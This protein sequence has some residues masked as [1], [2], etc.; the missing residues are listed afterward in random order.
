M[1]WT[2]TP[3]TLYEHPEHIFPTLKGDQIARFVAYG[4]LREVKS[5]QVLIEQGDQSFPF[6]L[7]SSGAMEVVRPTE[8]G[9][10]A[11]RGPVRKRTI[12]HASAPGDRQG[13]AGASPVQ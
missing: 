5:G 4:R 12:E 3:I 6:F 9:E 8:K 13:V 7:V 10:V 11:I 2:Q 1:P